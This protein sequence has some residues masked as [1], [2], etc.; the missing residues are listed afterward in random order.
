MHLLIRN[1]LFLQ[2]EL[3]IKILDQRRKKINRYKNLDKNICLD[4]L[5]RFHKKLEKLHHK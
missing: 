2:E 3:R 4:S 1:I 5:Y